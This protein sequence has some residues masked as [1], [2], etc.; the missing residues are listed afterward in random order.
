[1]DA[2]A[3]RN[4]LIGNKT[5]GSVDIDINT[6]N[7]LA[8]LKNISDVSIK[9]NDNLREEQEHKREWNREE[10]DDNETYIPLHTEIIPA[11]AVAAA[12]SF[13]ADIEPYSTVALQFNSKNVLGNQSSD[14][15]NSSMIT[16]LMN[17]INGTEMS[18]DAEGK[19]SPE[20]LIHTVMKSSVL[21]LK[22]KVIN[23]ILVI[24]FLS[25]VVLM[26]KLK[27]LV[28]FVNLEISMFLQNMLKI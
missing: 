20:A 9:A 28:F 10:H 25:N 15:I 18:V 14:I 24:F 23:I 6:S 12:N 27:Y 22:K 2:N 8:H 11:T 16:Y 5:N 26:E 21:I 4:Y 7:L 1:M 19:L 17:A 3:V 13:A